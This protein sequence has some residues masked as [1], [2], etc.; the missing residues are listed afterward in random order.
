MRGRPGKS[1]RP[2]LTVVEAGGLAEGCVGRECDHRYAVAVYGACTD[3]MGTGW[4]EPP[5]LHFKHLW[6]GIN[7]KRGCSWESN[8]WV[9]VVEFKRC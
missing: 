1:V 3:C 9:W 2:Q 6:D 5:T 8:P 7:A 4:S